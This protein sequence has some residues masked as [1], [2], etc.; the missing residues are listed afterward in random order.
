MVG[1]EGLG[2]F[3]DA[4][5]AK[6]CSRAAGGSGVQAGRPGRQLGAAGGEGAWP[7]G[8]AGGGGRGI[9][10]DDPEEIE[11]LQFF[12]FGGECGRRSMRMVGI[13]QLS[14]IS[15]SGK[16]FNDVD[17]AAFPIWFF[18]LSYFRV[19]YSNEGGYRRK[20]N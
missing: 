2:A 15:S 12:D 6:V 11:S 4:T 9:R 20:I 16:N 5:L 7:E 13:G 17:N 18:H 1:L 8:P 14:Q 3:L 19:R 10:L